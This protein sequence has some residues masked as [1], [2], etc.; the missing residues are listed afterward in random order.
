MQKSI[1]PTKEA[2]K[3][4]EK[5]LV[6]ELE[7]LRETTTVT[8]NLPMILI[9][10]AII[11]AGG[12]SG[13]VLSRTTG[14]SSLT[15]LTGTGIVVKEVGLTCEQKGGEVPEGTLK[16]GGIDGEGTHH[17]EREGG[18]ARNVYLT[19]SAVALDDFMGKKVRVCGD[20]MAAE[21]AGWLID[22][23]KVELLE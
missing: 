14:S 7:P 19:S 1:L 18:P 13:Y 2:E 6:K 11:V 3:V 15:S 16:E 9:G 22:V 4:I 21:Q 17:L 23:L 12:F 10:L 20:T 5:P 8:V